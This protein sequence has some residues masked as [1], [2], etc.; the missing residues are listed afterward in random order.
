MTSPERYLD[1]PFLPGESP[2]QCKGI[3]YVDSIAY[4]DEHVPGGWAGLTDRIR[5]PRLKAYLSQRFLAGTW[6]DVFP[7]VA[8]HRITAI[9]AGTPYLDFLRTMAAWTTDRQ[10][11]GVYRVFLKD[12][13][14]DA[15][16]RRLPI[17]AAKYYNCLRVEVRELAPNAYETL[18]SGLPVVVAPSYQVTSEVAVMKALEIAGVRHLRHRWMP[19]EPDGEAHGLPLVRVRREVRW[20]F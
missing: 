12:G 4:Y 10:Y 19:T 13:R 18:T 1:V 3:L 17:I 2:F 11:R 14:P 9:S 20:D 6:Y 15:V 8:A 16:A 5:D 7:T